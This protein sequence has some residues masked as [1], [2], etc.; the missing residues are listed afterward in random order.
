MSDE[1]APAAA[2]D[3]VM[4]KLRRKMV[5]LLAISI[6]VLFV[7]LI[8]VLSAV[9][10]RTGG[11]EGRG[12]A[13]APTLE[14]TIPVPAG[15]RVVS[16]TAGEGDRAFLLIETATGGQQLLVVEAGTGRVVSRLSL[17]NTRPGG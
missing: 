11:G 2:M 3:P 15:A 17:E 14:A 7:G 9:V 16:V 1:K 8:A 10:Y 5:R 13:D 12:G 6:A 4:E